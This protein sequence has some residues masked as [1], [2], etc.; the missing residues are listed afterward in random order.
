MEKIHNF[1]TSGIT[2]PRRVTFDTSASLGKSRDIGKKK[3]V[4]L[5]NRFSSITASTKKRISKIF[6]SSL[7]Y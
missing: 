6:D 2:R 4:Y 7:Q 3:N 5:A 1:K